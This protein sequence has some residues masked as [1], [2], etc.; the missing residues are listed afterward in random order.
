MKVFQT[1]EKHNRVNEE[2]DLGEISEKEEQLIEKV[3]EFVNT[4]TN[5]YNQYRIGNKAETVMEDGDAVDI[6]IS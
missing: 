6:R 1:D 3:L 5:R 4:H 2:L